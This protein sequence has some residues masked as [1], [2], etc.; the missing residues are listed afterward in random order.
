M[1]SYCEIGQRQGRVINGKELTVEVLLG[2]TSVL[3]DIFLGS[4]T[5][6]EEG[7][8]GVFAVVKEVFS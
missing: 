6:R 2:C 8:D 3:T 5:D 4:L 7:K 1:G